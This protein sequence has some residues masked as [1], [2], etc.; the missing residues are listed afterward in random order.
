MKPT[1]TPRDMTPQKSGSVGSM[2]RM[3][4]PIIKKIITGNIPAA[5]MF[6]ENHSGIN[7]FFTALG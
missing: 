2:A 6:I 5:I 1:I 7:E 3:S 4:R